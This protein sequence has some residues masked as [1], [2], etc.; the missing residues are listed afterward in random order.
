MEEV[1]GG[2]LDAGC[3]E[4]EIV[5]WIPA[6]AGMAMVGIPAPAFAAT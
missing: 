1:G 6:F 3:K 2:W 4:K 5:Y